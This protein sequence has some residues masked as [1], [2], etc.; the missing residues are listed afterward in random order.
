MKKN[1]LIS[2]VLLITSLYSNVFAQTYNMTWT[3]AAT[4]TLKYWDDPANWSGGDAINMPYPYSHNNTLIAI[5]N[6]NGDATVTFKS[7]QQ[8]FVQQLNINSGNVVFS[9]EV[10]ANPIRATLFVE[11]ASS[12]GINMNIASGATLVLANNDIGMLL[13]NY[14]GV[15]NIS[16]TM[17]IAGTSISNLFYGGYEHN[18]SGSLYVTNVNSGGVIKVSG[19][20]ARINTTSNTT[21]NFL[22][23]S[24]LWFTR[25]GSLIPAAKYFSGSNIQCD[26]TTLY[27]SSATYG[28]DIH[29][30][31]PAQSGI[32]GDY[33]WGISTLSNV[34][35]GTLYMQAGHLRLTSSGY[36]GSSFAAINVSGGSLD[37]RPTAASTTTVGSI[38]VGGGYFGVCGNALGNSA[39]MTMN[40]SGD[41]TQR[42]GTLDLSQG[43]ANGTLNVSGN[44]LQTGGT[45]TESGSSTLSAL[46]FTG[47][48]LQNATFSG[49]V[50]GDKFLVSINNLGNHVNLLANAILP[51]RLQC[52]SGDMI[53]G[54]NNLTVT[55]AVFGSRTGG[56]VVT[57]GT[58]ALTLKNVDTGLNGKDFP[59]AVSSASHDAVFITNAAGTADFTVRVSTTLSP[60]TGLN[61]ANT[62]PRQ[63]EITSTSTVANLEFDPD[64]LAG[65]RP[66]AGTRAIAHYV[67]GNW[68]Q[69]NAVDG[70]NQGYP[71]SANFTSFSPFVVGTANVIPVELTSFKASAKNAIN[72]LTWTTAS[73]INASHFDIERSANGL[74]DWLSIGTIKA[75]GNSLTLRKYEFS[76][77]APLALGYYRLR[78]VDFNG[79]NVA[80]NIIS[81]NR[82]NN[83]KLTLTKAISTLNTEGGN[84]SL[85]INTAKA[86][87]VTLLLTDAIGRV[88]LTKTFAT[89]EGDNT[90]QCPISGLA[91]GVYILSI[92][93]GD[94]RITTKIAHQ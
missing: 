94:S 10:V 77:E 1:L 22:S 91:K 61:L 56:S 80:S 5:A 18:G 38:T 72:L 89:T 85:E 6:F 42:G 67:G 25:S 34:F 78:S 21:L 83:A 7:G 16:G 3:G 57:N 15:A 75:S 65:A 54:S 46:N 36:A 8:T 44:V 28:G 71:F 81:V 48:S 69:S 2:F 13:K 32:L 82:Q 62:L 27:N 92:T 29:W 19:A 86:S 79:K 74:N 55:G 24:T 45:M 20:G 70:L 35:G 41:I 31:V 50:S 76:D 66:A 88:V 4:T 9:T 11:A 47:T 60:T 39:N 30:N 33:T 58:G 64:A 84:F 52:S 51:Y 40:I 23:G 90:L 63:W 12:A 87:T 68:V 49:T 73:E 17:D 14:F 53:L 43:T 59:V 93:D 26:N 37:F